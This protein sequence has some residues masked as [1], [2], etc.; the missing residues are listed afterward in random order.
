MLHHSQ[1]GFYEQAFRPVPQNINF[2][3]EQAEKP[4]A[5]NGARYQLNRDVAPFS[6][7]LSGA[8]SPAQLLLP[9]TK[10]T[11][12]GTGILPVLENDAAM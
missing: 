4:V 2:L 3:V 8:G 1:Q 10:F 6:T 5:D 7:S 9:K 11:L 12:C